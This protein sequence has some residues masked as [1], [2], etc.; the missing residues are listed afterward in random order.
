MATL[1]ATKKT[2]KCRIKKL[3]NQ[4]CGVLRQNAEH[5]ITGRGVLHING[6]RIDITEIDGSEFVRTADLE[7]PWD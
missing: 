3:P 7:E 6:Q 4:C 1:T 5:T 2:E